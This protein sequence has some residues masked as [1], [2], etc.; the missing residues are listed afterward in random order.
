MFLVMIFSLILCI[1]CLINFV[2]NIK[3]KKSKRS[4]VY[5][6]SGLLMF[7]VFVTLALPR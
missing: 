5:L 2:S 4:I 3:N 7:G 6:V 1:F